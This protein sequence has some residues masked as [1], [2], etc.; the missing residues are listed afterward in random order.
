MLRI[1]SVHEDMRDVADPEKN[2]RPSSYDMDYTPN[3]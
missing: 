2:A 1:M 3:R